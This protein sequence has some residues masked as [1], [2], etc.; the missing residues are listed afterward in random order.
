MVDAPKVEQ[1]TPFIPAAGD[2]QRVFA[3]SESMYTGTMVYLAAMT[4]LRQGELLALRWRDID[5]ASQ[6]LLVQRSAQ[7]LPGKGTTFK[8]PKT[9]RSLRSVPLTND[10]VARLRKHRA[11]QA[12]AKLAD[13]RKW[14]DQDLVFPGRLGEPMAPSWVK[15]NWNQIRLKA[16][17]PEMRFHDLRHM[18]ATLLLNMG[19]HPK[20]VSDRL[21]HSGIQVT[22][23]T[24]SHVMDGL[25]AEAIKG[26][27][28]VVAG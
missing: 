27:D 17:V 19:V 14:K 10:T 15:S 8:K 21:G 16:H 3:V 28:R 9:R 25:Q 18:H 22:M 1:P 12:E 13:G 5:L 6:K 2:I 4:G 11:Q 24:Y 7:W 26:L 20:V 23:D